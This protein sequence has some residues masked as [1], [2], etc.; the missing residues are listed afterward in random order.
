MAE[1]ETESQYK[2]GFIGRVREARI[3][4]ALKQWQI[5]D[6]LGM[7]QDK[8][9]Q[10]ETR[11]YLPHHLIGRFCV[12]CRVDPDWLITGH[13]KRSPKG[14]RVACDKSPLRDYTDAIIDVWKNL[15]LG[16]EDK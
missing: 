15:P 7:A 11:S 9:K 2:R 4:R 8:Y 14:L 10:Y 12:I 5:A 13:G 3:A 16:I 1:T 6:A